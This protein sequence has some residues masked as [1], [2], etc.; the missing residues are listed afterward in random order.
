MPHCK[1]YSAVKTYLILP[2]ALGQVA[3]LFH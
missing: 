2:Q 3:H 1:H